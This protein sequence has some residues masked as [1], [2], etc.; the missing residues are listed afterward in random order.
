MM[1]LY[2]EK[3]YFSISNHVLKAYAICGL[4]GAGKTTMIASISDQADCVTS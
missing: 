3:D 4:N 1:V 2:H